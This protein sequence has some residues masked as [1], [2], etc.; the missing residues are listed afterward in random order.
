[1][2]LALATLA[3]T[4]MVVQ[5]AIEASTST[6]RNVRQTGLGRGTANAA[7]NDADSERRGASEIV[8]M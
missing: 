6:K 4:I 1:M 8:V 2:R 7:G 5:S 3:P